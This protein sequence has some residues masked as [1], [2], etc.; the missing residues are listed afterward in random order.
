MIEEIEGKYGTLICKEMSKEFDIFYF[1]QYA[2][3]LVCRA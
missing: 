3:K 1:W 2:D